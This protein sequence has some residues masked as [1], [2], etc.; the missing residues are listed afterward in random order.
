MTWTWRKYSSDKEESVFIASNVKLELDSHK[1][2]N[3][4]TEIILK[5]LDIEILY[6]LTLNLMST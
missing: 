6:L 1:T 4:V 2:N 5:N 3:Y